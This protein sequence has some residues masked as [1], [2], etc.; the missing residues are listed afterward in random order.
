LPQRPRVAERC[1]YR[2]ALA[3]PVSEPHLR[4]QHI[5]F[6]DR[7]TAVAPVL[8]AFRRLRDNTRV[9]STIVCVAASPWTQR[10]FGMRSKQDSSRNLHYDIR[11][12]PDSPLVRQFLPE[13]CTAPPPPAKTSFLV[14]TTRASSCAHLPA[15]PQMMPGQ[16]LVASFIA[17]GI[18]AIAP[19]VASYQHLND[20]HAIDL[21]VPSKIR[22]MRESR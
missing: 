17:A 4:G 13:F 6:V 21:V 16:N 2:R 15:P 9:A 10:L 1:V 8:N 14:R 5:A 3:K 20:Q 19:I 18:S 11:K 7:V 22:L 12:R